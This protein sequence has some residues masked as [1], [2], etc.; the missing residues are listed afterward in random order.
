MKPGSLAALYRARFD[1]ADQAWKRQVWGVLWE[2]EFSRLIS[3]G[4]TLLD[5]GGGYCELVNQAV[6]RRRIVVD[7]NPEV[8]ER[9]A[10]GV[11]VHVGPA[12]DLSFLA[13]GEVSVVFT[14]NFLEHLPDK[15]AVARVLGE[16]ARV[17]APGGRLVALG[18]NVRLMP[19]AYWDYW[20]HQV[21][22]SERS[23]AEMLGGMGFQLERV[24][25]GF[26]PASTRS[27]LPRWRWLVEAWLALRPLSSAL[28]GKQF[29]VL[30]RKP[31]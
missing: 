21:A 28:A 24:E 29:L 5:L 16:A 30:A 9:A 12:D 26:L 18:P 14:S 15:A 10:P 25:P 22:L 17:L 3:P 6:A 1:D 13:D 20:D 8:A 19:G 23:L 2:R 31:G 11:E 4:D 27:R 7:L